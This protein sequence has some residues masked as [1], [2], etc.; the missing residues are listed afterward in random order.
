MD[1]IVQEQ[2]LSA[3]NKLVEMAGDAVNN[4]ASYTDTLT[5]YLP[6]WDPYYVPEW[7]TV[8]MTYVF[9]C[10]PLFS[11]GTTVISVERSKTAL[12]FSIDICATMLIASILR[13]SYYFIEPFEIALLRQSMCMVFIQ[14]ILLRTTLK[15]RPEEYKYDNLQT[16]EPFTQLIHDV[17]FEYFAIR[18]KPTMFSEEWRNLLKSLSFKRLLG[19]SIKITLVFV[20]KFLKFFDPSFKRIWSF[21]QWNDDRMYWKFLVI[22]ALFQF[23]FTF[24]ILN[25]EDLTH[26][27]GPVIGALGLLIESLLPLPQISILYKLKSVQGFKL[28][29]LVSWLCG[30]TYKLFFLLVL[31]NRKRSSLFVFFALFQMSLDFYIGGQYIYYKFYYNPEGTVVGGNGFTSTSASTSSPADQ[32]IDMSQTTPKLYDSDTYPGIPMVEKEPLTIDTGSPKFLKDEV[33]SSGR[34]LSIT[35]VH[36]S[37]QASRH[38]S[39]SNLYKDDKQK[40]HP[41]HF[42]M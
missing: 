31:G 1:E 15:Y 27:I 17:W 7:L 38:A 6:R 14:I 41:Q 22:F 25:W 20:Y 23:F 10:T 3:A 8:T 39:I 29:L 34:R 13:I 32:V 9:S 35:Q 26:S 19:F 30:D 4:H 24:L 18:S 11:Y 16:V 40:N 5:S 28:I 36:M 2:E 21:W 37:P 12:G 33:T 42:S